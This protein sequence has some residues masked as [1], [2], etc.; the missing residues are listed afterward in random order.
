MSHRRR[1]RDGV[2]AFFGRRAVGLS[3]ALGVFLL[4]GHV[5]KLVLS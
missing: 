4:V 5:A 2:A 1:L 3:I